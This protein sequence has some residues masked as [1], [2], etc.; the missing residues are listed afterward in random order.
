MNE[1]NNNGRGIFYGVIG[2]A[3]LIVAIIGATF[4]FFTATSENNNVITGNAASVSFSLLVNKVTDADN[5]SG[6]IPMTDAMVEKAVTSE[7]DRAVCEDDQGNAVC[8]IYE[9]TVTNNGTAGMFLDGYVNLT[10]GLSTSAS[11]SATTMRWAQVIATTSGSDTTYS[12]SGT[13]TIATGVSH[14]ITWAAATTSTGSNKDTLPAADLSLGSLGS[15]SY[16]GTSYDAIANNYVRTSIA[17]PATY[18]HSSGPAALV[19]NQNLAPNGSA[20]LYIVVWLNETESNQNPANASE[21]TN[22]FSGTVLFNSGAGGEVSATF[23]GYARTSGG[24]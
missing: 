19:F 4:A 13:H 10:G 21:A 2:V 16:N 17:N 7:G 1:K 6:M 12:M 5:Q 24:A 8:Q 14:T 22:F 23:S 15:Y 11:A 18:T 20:K 3:T 9:I